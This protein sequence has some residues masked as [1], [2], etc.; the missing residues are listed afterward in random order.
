[1]QWDYLEESQ[2]PVLELL[3]YRKKIINSFTVFGSV[4]VAHNFFRVH[5]FRALSFNIFYVKKNFS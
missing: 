5:S 3:R 1:M 4:Q 2:E